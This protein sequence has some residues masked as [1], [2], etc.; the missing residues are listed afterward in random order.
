MDEIKLISVKPAPEG[1]RNTFGWVSA[2]L[3]NGVC[4]FDIKLA[5]RSHGIFGY[6]DSRG[7]RHVCLHPPIAEK[8]VRM[9]FGKE[10]LQ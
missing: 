7:G 5:R 2:D 8:L 9:A 4:V 10:A 3:G 1:M 6:G